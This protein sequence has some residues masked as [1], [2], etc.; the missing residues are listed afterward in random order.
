MINCE[1]CN[2]KFTFFDRL[3]SIFTGKLKCKNCSSKYVPRA[4]F[5][6]FL[7]FFLVIFLNNTYIISSNYFNISYFGVKSFDKKLFL[8]ILIFLILLPSYD[9]FFYRFNHY[10]KVD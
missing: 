6:R 10:K 9:L 1:E 3:K 5:T 4:N 2:Y 7:Y 8:S